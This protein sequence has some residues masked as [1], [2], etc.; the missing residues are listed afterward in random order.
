MRRWIV[1][2]MILGFVIGGGC[3]KKPQAVSSGSELQG[4]IS[5]SGAFALYPMQDAGYHQVWG[6][7]SMP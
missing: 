1:T 6:H 2:T 5:L 3:A 7:A 4:T